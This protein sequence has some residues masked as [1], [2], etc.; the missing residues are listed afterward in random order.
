MTLR[1][2]PPWSNPLIEQACK[3]SK[4]KAFHFLD[5]SS[6]QQYIFFYSTNTSHNWN[7]FKE[8]GGQ[9]A[10]EGA[11][12]FKSLTGSNSG[13]VG[14]GSIHRVD[15]VLLSYYLGWFFIKPELVQPPNRPGLKST[16]QA[17]L[18]LITMLLGLKDLMEIKSTIG[19]F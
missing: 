4:K 16:H 9:G 1:T 2:I 3:R 18:D 17:G 14:H 5:L 11:A 19:T 15:R 7:E 6:N 8:E 13:L 10:H 12:L